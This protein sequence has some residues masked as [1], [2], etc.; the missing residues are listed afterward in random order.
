M[1]HNFY[2]SKYSI[3][4]VSDV[5]DILKIHIQTMIKGQGYD[6]YVS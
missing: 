1:M 3:L 4:H 6:K 2:F 5:I